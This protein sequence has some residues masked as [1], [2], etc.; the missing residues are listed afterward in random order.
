[1]LTL[2]TLKLIIAVCTQGQ[3]LDKK[4]YDE[5]LKCNDEYIS[6]MLEPIRPRSLAHCI[7]K[8]VASISVTNRPPRCK[9]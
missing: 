4:C 6:V 1:M 5:I 9:Y 3:V 8:G 7:S 2:I